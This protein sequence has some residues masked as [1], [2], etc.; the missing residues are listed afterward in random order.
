[1]KYIALIL[2]GLLSCTLFQAQSQS[3]TGVARSLRYQPAGSDFVINNGTHRFNRAIYGSNT[4][5]RVEAGDLP[6]FALYLPGMGGNL[7]LGLNDAQGSKWLID[8][9]NITARYRPGSMI[10][11]ISDPMLGTG[12]LQITVLALADAEGMIVQLSSK[13]IPANLSLFAAF[14]G[15]TGKKFLARRR[16]RRRSRIVVLP[17]T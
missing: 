14:G 5:F 7:R 13:N 2:A 3:K 11:T 4:A 1:M 12:N 6:E 9:K 15:V 8:A 16:F 10:Y 17:E